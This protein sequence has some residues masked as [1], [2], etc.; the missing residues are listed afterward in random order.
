MRTATT[1]C[2]YPS[3]DRFRTLIASL[4]EYASV[5][6]PWPRGYLAKKT[7][8]SPNV[9]LVLDL[10]ETLIVSSC[11]PIQAHDFTISFSEDSETVEVQAPRH[12]QVYVRLRPFVKQFLAE[13]AK[14]FEVVLF[15]AAEV[16]PGLASL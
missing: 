4:P 8:R 11:N 10:D 1:P 7:R 14:H 5:A 13:V 9:T 2:S 3:A 15:T 6:D 12:L 16:R